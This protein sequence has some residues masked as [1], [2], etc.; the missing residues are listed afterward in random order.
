VSLL[1]LANACAPLHYPVNAP[2]PQL[3]ADQKQG[4]YASNIDQGRSDDMQVFVSFSGGG[5]RAAAFAYGVMEVLA[6]T[7]IVWDGK[8]ERL[9]DEVDIFSG[10]SGV[11]F[12]AAYYGLFGDRIFEDFLP[13]FLKYN[14]QEEL[15]DRMLSPTNWPG[16]SSPFY[17]RSDM[18][19]EFYDQQLFEGK[20]FADIQASGGPAIIIN[21]TD[22]TLGSQFTFDQFQ[23]DLL[24]S[25]VSK[26]PVSRAVAASSAVPILFSSV[27]IRNYAGDCQYIPPSWAVGALKERETNSRRFHQASQLA[28]SLDRNDRPYIHLYDG[29]LADNLGVR[30]L[31]DR[32]SLGGDI[33][34]LLQARQL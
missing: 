20:T 1:L 3:S 4:Y 17:G 2:L 7:P 31:L 14:I 28:A 24:C 12:P 22:A 13:R 16:L 15:T 26:F 29:G 25:D 6:D 23:F 19:A 8:Q 21:A 18:A 32:V 10:V 11:S 34:K 30:P 5:T 27:T 33:W 9:L